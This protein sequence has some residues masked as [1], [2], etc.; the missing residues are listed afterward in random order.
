MACPLSIFTRV[1]EKNRS[2]VDIGE[3]AQRRED[4]KT[5][6]RRMAM[7]V[8]VAREISRE[9]VSSCHQTVTDFNH[10]L[11]EVG[12]NGLRPVPSGYGLAPDPEGAIGGP[13]RLLPQWKPACIFAGRPG[14]GDGM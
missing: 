4:R 3:E 13:T 14:A 9:R 10:P 5:A 11:S 7:A 6:D 8:A 2:A 1:A 12:W